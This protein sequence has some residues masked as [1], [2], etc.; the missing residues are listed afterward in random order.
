MFEEIIIIP[1][2][3]E[4]YS[5]KKILKQLSKKYKLIV[6]DDGSKDST[7]K[8]LN[9][10]KIESITNKKNI[11]YEKSLIKA[12]NY[13]I[14]KY[15]NIKNII[16]FDADGEHKTSDLNKII[17]FSKIRKPALLIC[18][19]KNIKRFSE[20]IINYF[21][22]IKFNV[23]DP[24][25]GLKIYNIKILKKYLNKIKPDH[26]LVNLAK[27]ICVNKHKVLNFPIKCNI[28]GNRQPRIG[29]YFLS[30]IKIL[31]ILLII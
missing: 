11:G 1:S 17:T 30:N 19:R 25:S 6:I 26:F 20:K 31:K 10:F 27:K 24:L 4:L 14:E 28:I 5:L 9:A 13:T 21:F 15:P 23:E 29:N 12:F 18:N 3:N 22:K 7:S 8:M 16:T 2:F